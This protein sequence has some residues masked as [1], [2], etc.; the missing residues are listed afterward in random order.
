MTGNGLPGTRTQSRVISLE[1][2]NNMLPLLGKIVRDIT[3]TWEQ[4]IQKRTELECLEKNPEST[5]SEQRDEIMELKGDL[6]RLIDKINGYIREI[7]ELGCFVEEFKRGV[8]NFPSLYVGRK[9][10]LCWKPGDGEVRFWHELDE[11]YSER[12]PIRDCR[13]FLVSKRDV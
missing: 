2:A 12:T 9:V 1:E 7:E 10:F 4:I 3:S 6:N 5:G 13:H 8:I 11:S